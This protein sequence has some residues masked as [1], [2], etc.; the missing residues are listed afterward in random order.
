MIAALREKVS[1]KVVAQIPKRTL[2]MNIEALARMYGPTLVS[3]MQLVD[4]PA[5]VAGDATAAVVPLPGGVVAAAVASSVGG[6]PA[7]VPL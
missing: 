3:W 2:V 6:A 1:A 7:G 5:A 4:E